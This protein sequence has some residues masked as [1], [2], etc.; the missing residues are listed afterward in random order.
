MRKRRY[1]RHWK[2]D[3]NSLQLRSAVGSLIRRRRCGSGSGCRPRTGFGPG[4][5]LPGLVPGERRLGCGIGDRLLDLLQV[6]IVVLE[7]RLDVRSQIGRA[8]D[9]G[10]HGGGVGARFV[11]QLKHVLFLIGRSRRRKQLTAFQVLESERAAELDRAIGTS[12]IY[13]CPAGL[14][15][16]RPR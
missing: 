7:R 15:V 3:W 8:R 6:H 12:L 9:L 1:S 5:R 2:W 10:L 13:R 11:E 16:N 14:I 4:R